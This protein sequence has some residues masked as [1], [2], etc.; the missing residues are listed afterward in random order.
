MAENGPRVKWCLGGE[1]GIWRVNA[2][3]V[4][5]N[6]LRRRHPAEGR[7]GAMGQCI[8]IVPLQWNDGRDDYGDGT[9]TAT[10]LAS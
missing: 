6:E 10:E 5:T 1:A 3:G 7:G 9:G 2:G 8:V 4:A